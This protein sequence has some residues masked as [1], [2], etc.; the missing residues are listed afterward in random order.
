MNRWTEMLSRNQT[1]HIKCLVLLCLLGF[2][3]GCQEDE[4]SVPAQPPPTIRRGIGFTPRSFDSTGMADFFAKA[5]EA[6]D[7]VMWA[8]D[9]I[10]LA[11]SVGGPAVVAGLA[12]VY[13]YTPLIIAQFFSQ[14]GD[15]L[16][17]PLNDSVREMYSSCAGAFAR[18]FQPE[19]LGFGLEINV[20]Y[21]HS[22][23]DFDIFAD[24]FPVVCDSVKA[25]S[26]STQV[27]TVFQLEKMKGL[28]GGLFGGVNDTSNS[29]WFLLEQFPRS[30]ILALTTYPGL[31]F[32][33]PSEI[34]SDYYTEI[35]A[36]TS[37]PVA[38]TEI[39][40]HSNPSPQGWESSESEQAEFVTRF[41]DLVEPLDPE[42]A[43]WSFLYDQDT[44]E[45]F[46]SMGL[47]RRSDGGAKLAWS[48]WIGGGQ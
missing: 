36:R 43:V 30:E 34:S 1:A 45:P 25:Q 14:S 47:C 48:V 27:F 6:G 38:F 5:A 11:D 19:Y 40:W 7:I 46:N 31:V 44:D 20:L 29:Q 10:E 41:F 9:W 39:G 3:L 21:E 22:P 16:L 2:G 12:S 37:K 17:R 32:T 26:P 28:N 4:P 15:S 23:S 24:F 18:R 8:G 33:N 42:F 35:R 13:H